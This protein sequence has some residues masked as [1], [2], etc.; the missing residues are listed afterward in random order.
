MASNYT[1]NMKGGYPFSSG[2]TNSLSYKVAKAGEGKQKQT[3]F[4]YEKVSI[5]VS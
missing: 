2:T 4:K 5:P 1:G 3:Q